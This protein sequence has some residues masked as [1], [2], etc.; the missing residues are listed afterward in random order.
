[1]QK[2]KKQAVKKVDN[3]KPRGSWALGPEHP[4]WFPMAQGETLFQLIAWMVNQMPEQAARAF[5][6]GL[7]EKATEQ[8][9]RWKAMWAE[10]RKEA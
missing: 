5:T 1:M 6:M 2:Q 9:E 7:V 3:P 4:D 10:Q 8:A